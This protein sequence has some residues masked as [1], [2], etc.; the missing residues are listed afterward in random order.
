MSHGFHANRLPRIAAHID[1]YVESGKLPGALC[2]VSRGGEEAFFHACGMRDVERGAP[3]QRDTVVRFYS[4]TKPIASVA[5]MMPL[6]RKGAFSSTIRSPR[7]ST[8]G[9]IWRFSTGATQSAT[10]LS[11]RP[12]P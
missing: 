6:P 3:M 4:M 11:S 12:P 7:P 1:R 9:A 8:A 5:L 10:S 2:L